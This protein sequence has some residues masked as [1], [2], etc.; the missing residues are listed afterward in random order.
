M[1]SNPQVKLSTF[2][3][4]IVFN[5]NPKFKE[6]LLFSQRR[7][8]YLLNTHCQKCTIFPS[9]AQL[10]QNDHRSL[11]IKYNLSKRRGIDRKHVAIARRKMHA[12]TFRQEAPYAMNRI[13]NKYMHYDARENFTATNSWK[14]S[15]LKFR[16]RRNRSDRREMRRT[17]L[18]EERPYR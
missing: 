10:L 17:T 6:F 7:N 16:C 5:S 4:R 13:S 2:N 14:K 9:D 15:R 3:V 1:F 11:I 8:I 18:R 12:L